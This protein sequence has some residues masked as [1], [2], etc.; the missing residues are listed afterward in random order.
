MGAE[1]QAKSGPCL[2]YDKGSQERELAVVAESEKSFQGG[3]S[4]AAEGLSA[5]GVGGGVRKGPEAVCTTE[6]CSRCCFA[7]CKLQGQDTGLDVVGQ[8]R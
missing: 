6:H 8:N 4:G 2:V 3:G 7:S 1:R 5:E